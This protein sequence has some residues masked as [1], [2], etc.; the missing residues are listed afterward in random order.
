MS[1]GGDHKNDIEQGRARCPVCFCV[2]PCTAHPAPPKLSFAGGTDFDKRNNRIDQKEECPQNETEEEAAPAQDSR[3]AD[4]LKSPFDDGG[5]PLRD[6]PLDAG[7]SDKVGEAGPELRAE[8]PGDVPV[9]DNI[10]PFTGLT[11]LPTDPKQILEQAIKHGLQ[12]AIV[13]GIDNA[14]EEYFA[15]STGDTHT[16][17]FFLDRAKLDV[18]RA[19]EDE[20]DLG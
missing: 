18:M 13:I 19:Y 3:S 14:G 1:D 11:I 15:Y 7:T 6:S 20:N 4:N 16:V 10:V 8:L 5:W 17:N 2:L 9:Q 12:M